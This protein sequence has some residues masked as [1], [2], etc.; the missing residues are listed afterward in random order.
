MRIS[1]WSSDVCSSDLLRRERLL[2]QRRRIG[3]VIQEGGLFPHLTAAD[4]VALV[5][6][7]LGW[8]AAKIEERSRE[9]ARLCALPDG[10]LQR[11]PAELSG[12][13]RQ[14]VGLVRALM[15]DPPVLLLEDRKST[16]LNSSH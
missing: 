14:R 13:Q 11:Y 12:G 1:D 7:L 4:N 5:A 16:R 3:Y 10:L 15:L 6:R 8:S 9:L 2:E